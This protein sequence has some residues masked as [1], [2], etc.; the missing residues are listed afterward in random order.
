[1]AFRNAQTLHKLQTMNIGQ[2]EFGTLKFVEDRYSELVETTSTNEEILGSKIRTQCY[3]KL[4]DQITRIS[5]VNTSL[6]SQLS[7]WQK[8]LLREQKNF[9]KAEQL[10]NKK[11]ANLSR[12]VFDNYNKAVS[13]Y[14]NFRS[15]YDSSTSTLLDQL[16]QTECDRSQ[17][18]HRIL[19]L[20][21]EIRQVMVQQS[22]R[23]IDTISKHIANID[24]HSDTMIFVEKYR[25][26]KRR[27][28]LPEFQFHPNDERK[29][30]VSNS[31][32][33][34]PHKENENKRNDLINKDEKKDIDVDQNMSN[35]KTSPVG[36]NTTKPVNKDSDSAQLVKFKKTIDDLQNEK[37][38]L[39]ET[40]ATTE[41]EKKELERILTDALKQN[42]F[43]CSESM[44]LKEE[45]LR[46]KET[47]N[48]LLKQEKDK[49]EEKKEETVAL[50]DKI[51]F[52]NQ[53]MN[54]FV[55]EYNHKT[56]LEM[57]EIDPNSL[58]VTQQLETLELT[59][60]TFVKALQDISAQ[61]KSLKLPNI[62]KFEQ[63]DVNKIIV[64]IQ[65]LDNGKYSKYCEVLRRGFVDDGIDTGEDLLAINEQKDLRNAP[66]E[67]KSLPDRKALIA[68]F[69]SLPILKQ[70]L[71]AENQNVNDVDEEGAVTPY[72][73]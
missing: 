34:Q 11:K 67:I 65:T 23:N 20:Y 41:N 28:P 30:V 52:L 10:F 47:N 33:S 22:L 19:K 57:Y 45:V 63:W 32:K 17:M 36:T 26:N 18:L 49:I 61:I 68:H 43:L 8:S 6:L 51:V 72:V 54:H 7:S 24:S 71:I 70:Q 38:H 50:N 69:Q 25:S 56:L 42:D 31:K 40:L 73:K 48:H 58:N 9:H 35:S 15:K 2:C 1:M 46:L 13:A 3:Q 5:K 53:K 21:L 64:W 27:Q 4:K 59:S 14:I 37:K 12:N 44:K 66:F 29:H 16:E 62:M 39:C 55:N 60:R